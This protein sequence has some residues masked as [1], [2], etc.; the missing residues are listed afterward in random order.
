MAESD[1]KMDKQ[2][3]S[4]SSCANDQPRKSVFPPPEKVM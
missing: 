1:D 3:T 4:S 2:L